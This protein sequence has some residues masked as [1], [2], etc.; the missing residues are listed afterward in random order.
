[1][2]FN[3]PAAI[4]MLF[5][6][7]LVLFERSDRTLEALQVTPLA[8]WQYLLS[9]VLTLTLI[10]WACS[11][12]MALAGHGWPIHLLYFSLGI[13]LPSV[14]F[15]SIGFIVVLYSPSFNA[16]I[17]KVGLLLIPAV[18]PFLNFFGL[19]DTL[20]WY[21]VPVQGALILLE[22][23]MGKVFAAWEIIYSIGYLSI[24]SA[25]AFWWALRIFERKAA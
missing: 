6:G 4:G 1:L 16:Y 19:T 21:V 5:I 17:L 24:A 18:L 2:I 14:F 11:L 12:P 15:T 8:N 22:A 7:S 13:A 3:D 25:I 9:K 23:S 20:W 10:A